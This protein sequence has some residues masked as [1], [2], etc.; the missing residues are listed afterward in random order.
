VRGGTVEENIRFARSVLDGEHSPAR[1]VVMLNAGAALHVAG[2][3][4]DFEGGVKLAGELIDSGKVRQQ[5]ERIRQV[6]TDLRRQQGEA[7]PA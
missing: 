3:A 2:L 7:S 4:D 6:S 1:D 5:L